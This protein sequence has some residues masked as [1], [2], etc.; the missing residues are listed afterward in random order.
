VTSFTVV[1]LLADVRNERRASHAHFGASHGHFQASHSSSCFTDIFRLPT[2]C[3]A[4]R[5]FSGFPQTFSG[6]PQFVVLHGHFQ[7]SHSSSCFTDI[8]RLPTDIFRLPTVRRASQASF[9]TLNLAPRNQPKFFLLADF[10]WRISAMSD[11]LHSRASFG[12]YP[13]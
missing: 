3:R 7:A 1:L 2:V 10:F 11:E 6:F 4:S 13:Q 12:G 5:T 9:T 8:F